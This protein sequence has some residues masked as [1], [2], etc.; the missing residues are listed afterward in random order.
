MLRAAAQMARLYGKTP[1]EMLRHAVADWRVVEA[2][3]QIMLAA[4][5]TDAKDENP[6]RQVYW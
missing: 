1:S 2:A 4:D 3:T 6:A 5:G